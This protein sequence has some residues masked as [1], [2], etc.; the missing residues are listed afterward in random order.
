V[1]KP[2]TSTLTGNDPYPEI[3]LALRQIVEKSGRSDFKLYVTGYPA[4][5]NVDTTYCND[6]TFNHW[7]PYDKLLPTVTVGPFLDTNLVQSLNSFLS[8]LVN[9]FNSQ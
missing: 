6:V 8:G 3:F 1:I 2:A 4:F 9:D 7:F 5:L